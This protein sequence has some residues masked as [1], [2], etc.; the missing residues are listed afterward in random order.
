MKSEHSN[1]SHA[2]LYFLSTALIAAGFIA[3]L[4]LAYAANA[5][6]NDAFGFLFFTDTKFI[7]LV[8]TLAAV[9]LITLELP[10]AAV[11]V[12]YLILDR[13]EMKHHDA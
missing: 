13:K 5:C 12:G 6:V 1:K 7:N 11:G 10:L 9:G 4:G 8:K 2:K 3:V